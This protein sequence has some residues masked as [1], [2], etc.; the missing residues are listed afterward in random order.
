MLCGLYRFR[1]SARQDLTVCAV[2]RQYADTFSRLGQVETSVPTSGFAFEA[3]TEEDTSSLLCMF[4]EPTSSIFQ[5]HEGSVASSVDFRLLSIKYKDL[6]EEYDEVVRDLCA[7]DSLKSMSQ[8]PG[9]TSTVLRK[10][11]GEEAAKKGKKRKNRETFVTETAD[12]S[13]ETKQ[14][15]ASI[16]S[17]STLGTYTQLDNDMSRHKRISIANLHASEVLHAVSI[18]LLKQGVDIFS[19]TKK[20]ESAIVWH[21]TSPGRSLLQTLQQVGLRVNS[22]EWSAQLSP[23]VGR[24]AS[25]VNWLYTI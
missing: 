9:D 2:L 8:L 19:D 21:V 22:S 25:M 18:E 4:Q 23:S 14:A 1:A 15:R 11:L 16:N 24:S 5:T 6:L 13:K 3:L 7:P 17:Y 12:S 10:D 20:L